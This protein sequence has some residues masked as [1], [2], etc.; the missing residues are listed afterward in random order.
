MPRLTLREATLRVLRKAHNSVQPPATWCPLTTEEVV[1]RVRQFEGWE[2]VPADD[3]MVKLRL[4][5]DD[6]KIKLRLRHNGFAWSL[7]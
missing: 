3:V 6:E 1:E 7:T 2:E 5:E 4:L